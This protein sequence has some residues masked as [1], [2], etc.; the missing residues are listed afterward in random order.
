MKKRT[1]FITVISSLIPLG[2]PLIIKTGVVLST[3]GFIISIPAKAHAEST[4]N[5][6]HFVRNEFKKG[7]FYQAISNSNKS[8]YIDKATLIANMCGAKFNVVD[9]YEVI[10]NCNKTIEFDLR[11]S[12][13]FYNRSVSKEKIG[14]IKAAFFDA[15]KPG[16]FGNEDENNK[17]WIKKNC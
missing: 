5:Y 6:Y 8:V 3:I 14:D 7:N 4:S 10:F 16:E 17:I 12:L 2:Q 13:A 9:P 11:K 15:K 1:A